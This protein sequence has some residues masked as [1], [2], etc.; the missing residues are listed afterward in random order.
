[1]LG[2]PVVTGPVIDGEH[3]LLDCP[4]YTDETT[5]LYYM[6]TINDDTNFESQY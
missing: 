4:L 3:R 1:M 6:I 5:H 2:G